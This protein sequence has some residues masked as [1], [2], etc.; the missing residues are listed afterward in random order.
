MKKFDVFVTRT[1]YAEV[2]ADSYEDAV[3]QADSL[4]VDDISWSETFDEI[5]VQ[6]DE[7]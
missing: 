3:K 5:D 7:D 6:R 4:T 1:G 2:S